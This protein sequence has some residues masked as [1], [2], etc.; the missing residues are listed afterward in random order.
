MTAVSWVRN[1]G[2]HHCSLDA[3]SVRLRWLE[4]TQEHEEYIPIG[5]RGLSWFGL[6]GSM[7]NSK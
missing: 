6:S 4:L 7:S 3:R 1:R 2:K 5:H